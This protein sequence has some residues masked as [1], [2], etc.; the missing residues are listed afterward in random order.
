MHNPP[1]SSLSARPDREALL[2]AVHDLAEAAQV[3]REGWNGYNVLHDS[4]SRVAALDI[5]FA[6][7]AAARA[8][9]AP[10]AK[11]VYLL[12]ADDWDEAAVPKDAFVVYQ[13]RLRELAEH[14]GTHVS[15]C[16]WGSGASAQ[17]RFLF[18]PSEGFVR[19]MRILWPH[20]EC[21]TPPSLS[22]SHTCRSNLA[23]TPPCMQGH[24]GDRGASRAD[25]VLPAAAYTEKT[26]L[27]VN[28]EGRVQTTRAA[29]PFVGDAREDWR[30][31]RALSEVVGKTLPYDSQD[32]LRK[33]L[34]AVAP[35]FAKVWSAEVQGRV[36]HAGM[37]VEGAARRA[38]QA[39]ACSGAALC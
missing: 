34:A 5:G 25:V 3:V 31:L 4:A 1:C 11:F 13:V 6:P 10:A 36:W 20:T 17:A 16:L 35:H 14:A 8:P 38:A 2:K 29:V 28:T 37:G 24:H 33:R 39:A 15:V 30:I 19:C 26:A 21:I 18:V 9:K 23:H 27:Y 22:L 7:S 12:G 32:A